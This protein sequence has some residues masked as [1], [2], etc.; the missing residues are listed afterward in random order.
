MDVG[1]I[2][3]G[4]A[5]TG[6]VTFA[7]LIDQVINIF[8]QAKTDWKKY[9]F[10]AALVVAVGLTVA[11]G[12]DMFAAAGFTFQ[13]PYLGSVATGIA[14]S[15]GANYMHDGFKLVRALTESKKPN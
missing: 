8:I 15:R 2:T 5:F 3:L 4:G 6:L 10:W 14:M 7:L 12:V 13:V 1:T 9:E 11:A